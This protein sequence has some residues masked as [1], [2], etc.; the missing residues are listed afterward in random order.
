MRPPIHSNK[1]YVQYTNAT[2]AAGAVSTIELVKGVPQNAVVNTQDVVE[3]SVVKAVYVEYWVITTGTAGAE[4]Q[5]T[6]CIYKN[7]AGAAPMTLTNLAN[8][9]S[10]PNK[11]N[12]LYTTQGVFGDERTNSVPL[13]RGWLKIPKGKQRFGLEDEL[14]ISAVSIEQGMQR[15]GFSTYKEYM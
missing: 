1:H 10:Y 3:G 11:K 12:V 8:L 14:V 5:I 4:S 6:M 15:C 13:F 9:Q 7:V 2:I